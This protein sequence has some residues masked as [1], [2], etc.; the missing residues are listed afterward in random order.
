VIEHIDRRLPH[1]EGAL[2][3]REEIRG[4]CAMH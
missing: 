3:G 4:R 1:V 2:G